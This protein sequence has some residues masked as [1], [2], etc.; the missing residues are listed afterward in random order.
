M[1]QKNKKPEDANNE[2]SNEKINS[3]AIETNEANTNDETRLTKR[4]FLRFA[5]AGALTAAAPLP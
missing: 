4:G 5:G 2:A 3:P 1:H